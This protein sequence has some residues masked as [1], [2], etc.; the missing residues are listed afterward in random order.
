VVSPIL[1]VIIYRENIEKW[2]RKLQSGHHRRSREEKR[3]ETKE[4]FREP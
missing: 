1:F 3:R 2:F 4:R